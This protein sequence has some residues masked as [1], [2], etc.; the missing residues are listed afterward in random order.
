LANGTKS[1]LD[2]R[3]P[4]SAWKVPAATTCDVAATPLLLNTQSPG[5]DPDGKALAA[6]KYVNPSSNAQC[7]YRLVP[8]PI[9]NALPPNGGGTI[10]ILGV[11]SF[12][13]VNWYRD[14]GASS[15][16]AANVAD[17]TC[18]VVSKN[19]PSPAFVCGVVWG[20]LF[21]GVTPPDAL[22]NQIGSSNNPFAPLLIALVD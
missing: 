8:V 5:Y 13:V 1:G 4:A 11:A 2:D 15:E 18:H 16:Y 6:A 3:L 12:G 19:P 7:A 22:L 9:I 21:T 20:Y 17:P 10:T 14:N